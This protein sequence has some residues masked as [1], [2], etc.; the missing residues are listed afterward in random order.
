MESIVHE[1]FHGYAS[2]TITH[3]NRRYKSTLLIGTQKPNL[4]FQI[5]K[6]T[7]S[8]LSHVQMPT[9]HLDGDGEETLKRLM[10]CASKAFRA[11]VSIPFDP[12]KV[13]AL[14][15]EI[16]CDFILPR[17]VRTLATDCA[18]MITLAEL[19]GCYTRDEV[20]QYV[21]NVQVPILAQTCA[22]LTDW[23]RFIRD[24]SKL[25]R[26]GRVSDRYVKLDANVRMGGMRTSC[27]ALYLPSLFSHMRDDGFPIT[28][29]ESSVQ[30][31]A[32]RMPDSDVCVHKNV[33]F[34]GI[35]QRSLVIRTSLVDFGGQAAPE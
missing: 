9:G 27:I 19:T 30:K 22:T 1:A 35:V 26:E 6:A 11:I 4:G 32:K 14:A 13:D 16:E 18:A 15:G 25:L 31:E 17:A 23:A 28:Y 10:P 8:R 29:T 24:V 7:S 20:M 12:S 3:G 2:S 34:G 21:R 5:D 33:N